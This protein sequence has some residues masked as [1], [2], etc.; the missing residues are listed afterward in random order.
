MTPP[1]HQKSHV[2]VQ[3]DGGMS[4]HPHPVDIKVPQ[5]PAPVGGRQLQTLPGGAGQHL[6]V[7]YGAQPHGKAIHVQPTGLQPGGFVVVV[8]QSQLVVVAP[9]S[10]CL[11][12]C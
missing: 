3:Y 7:G 6:L 5:T 10:G 9:Q 1:I 8:L 11:F 2:P 12:A 4:Q